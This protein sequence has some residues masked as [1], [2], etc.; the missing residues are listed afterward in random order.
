MMPCCI[1]DYNIYLRPAAPIRTEAVVDFFDYFRSRPSSKRDDVRKRFGKA[2]MWEIIITAMILFGAFIVY[3]NLTV[4]RTPRNAA[5]QIDS[6]DW[7]DGSMGKAERE[8]SPFTVR[9]LRT[10]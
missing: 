3:Q 4:S 8:C 10:C 5:S 2:G 1:Y 7:N 6:T 9:A